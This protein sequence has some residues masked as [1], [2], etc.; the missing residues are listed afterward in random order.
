M[1]VWRT[2]GYTKYTYIPTY[3]SHFHLLTDLGFLN[4]TTSSQDI[5]GM[6]VSIYLNFIISAFRHILSSLTGALF[7]IRTQ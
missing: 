2:K 4:P 7:Q 6:R 1:T 3:L 5:R